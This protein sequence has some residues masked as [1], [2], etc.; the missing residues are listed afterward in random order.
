MFVVQYLNSSDFF[1]CMG[2]GDCSLAIFFWL[3]QGLRARAHLIVTAFWFII[4]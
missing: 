1:F 4:C 3:G 2:R